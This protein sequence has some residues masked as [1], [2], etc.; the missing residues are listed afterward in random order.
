MAGDAKTESGVGV[1]L[2]GLL[3]AAFWPAV[4]LTIFWSASDPLIN[5]L[6]EIPN[7][8]NRSDVITIG[9]F[10]IEMTKRVGAQVDDEIR[11][12]IAKL[13]SKTFSRLM[14]LEIT[15]S[16]CIYENDLGKGSEF[17]SVDQALE[18]QNLAIMEDN[19]E[20]E[21]E[22]QGTGITECYRTSPT[23]LGGRARGALIAFL[24]EAFK[25]I[26]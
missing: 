1:A 16:W 22:D 18:D 13:D 2:I 12:A 20:R 24:A 3:K 4:V 10:K 19:D 21:L 15:N 8:V 17:M 6:K 26:E 11:V 5:L 25:E 7:A 23:D 9:S 14:N